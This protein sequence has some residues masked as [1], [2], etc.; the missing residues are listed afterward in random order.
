MG[1]EP[2]GLIDVR[3]IVARMGR[4]DPAVSAISAEQHSLVTTAQLKF[5]GLDR[6]AVWYRSRRGTLHRLHRG[7]FAVGHPAIGMLSR[8]AAAVL[9]VGP[10]SVLSHHSAAAY[11]RMLD[12]VEGAVHVSILKARRSR[13]GIAVHRPV[14]LPRSDYSYR[15]LIPVTSPARTVVDLAGAGADFERAINEGKALRHFGDVQL[16]RAIDAS[17]DRLGAKRL[18]A[19]LDAEESPG[20]SRSA[21]ER[22]LKRLIGEA[23]LPPP[24][25]NVSVH[26]HELDLW[27]PESM[28]NAEVDGATTHTRNRNF[29]SDRARDA[30]LATRGI[31][32]LR[33]TW[34]QLTEEPSLV[35]GRLAAAIALRRS[36]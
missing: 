10:T 3:P 32:A 30:D 7:V 28:L 35:V 26:G 33:F 22:I 16:R 24:R 17:P 29:E 9:A 12:Y 1:T 11:W 19:H 6:D 25:R 8:F 20:F 31:Q 27:W 2:W 4:G 36:A 18:A 21:G 14:S 34:K 5:A 15:D 13:D 23:L